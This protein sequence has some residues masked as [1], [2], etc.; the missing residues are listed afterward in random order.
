[1]QFKNIEFEV[2][3]KKLRIFFEVP[4]LNT[5]TNWAPRNLIKKH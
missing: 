1:M 4:L 3:L 5:F 2:N